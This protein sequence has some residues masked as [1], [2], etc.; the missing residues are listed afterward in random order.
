MAVSHQDS[1]IS[2]LLDSSG[3]A[4]Y[5]A[6]WIL[7]EIIAGEMGKED[8]KCSAEHSLTQWSRFLR[9]HP[10]QAKSYLKSMQSAG[11]VDIEIIQSRY[12][13]SVSNLLKYRD[14]HSR[15]SGHA[16][17]SVRTNSSQIRSD[18][19]K[20]NHIRTDQNTGDSDC[21]SSSMNRDQDP[22]QPISSVLPPPGS[23]VGAAEEKANTN[24]WKDSTRLLPKRRVVT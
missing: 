10:N 15:K 11:L 7:L 21:S 18:H 5:G 1:K 16:P 14:E 17:E 6:W 12:R 3:L 24:G 13:V 2:R 9:C 22:V 20:I 19:N 4:G 8:Q 23:G